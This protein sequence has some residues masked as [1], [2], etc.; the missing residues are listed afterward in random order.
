MFGTSS[1]RSAQR[2]FPAVIAR[3]EQLVAV[4]PLHGGPETALGPA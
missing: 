4:P 2:A 1:P 3:I